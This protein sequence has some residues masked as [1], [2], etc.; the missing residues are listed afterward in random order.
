M[1]PEE[2]VRF[3]T[4]RLDGR[5]DIFSLGVVLYELI[6][7]QKPFPNGDSR[8]ELFDQNR[9]GG[10]TVALA[11]IDNRIPAELRIESA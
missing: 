9:L 2:Q 8:R 11:A 7:G 3:E 10:T 6:A 4:H 1:S 5:S